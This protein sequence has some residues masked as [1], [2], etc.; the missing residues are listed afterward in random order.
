ML[1]RKLAQESCLNAD[2]A[3]QY[4]IIRSMVGIGKFLTNKNEI[5]IFVFKN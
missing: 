1:E 5:E 3:L 2:T 4:I